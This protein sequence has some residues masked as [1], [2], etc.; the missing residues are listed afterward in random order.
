MLHLSSHGRIP[1]V[2]DR[3]IC[4]V[5]KRRFFRQTA[6]FKTKHATVVSDYRPGRSLEISAQRLPRRL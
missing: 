3:V 1:V 6:C 5:N 4:A 2:L